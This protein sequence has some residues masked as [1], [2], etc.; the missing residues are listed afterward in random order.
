MTARTG[1]RPARCGCR[2][3]GAVPAAAAARAWCVLPACVP[4]CAAPASAPRCRVPGAAVRVEGIAAA[5][6]AQTLR[7]QFDDALHRA[8]QLAVMANHQQAFGPAQQLLDQRL[9]AGPVEVIAGFVEDK[10]IRL[11]QPGANRLDRCCRP[12][13]GPAPP[14]LAARQ[15]V[16]RR[17]GDGRKF[18]SVRRITCGH[19]PAHG[20]R[21]PAP[22]KESSC[23]SNRCVKTPTRLRGW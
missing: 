18:R 15:P 10:K 8:R 5:I 22:D 23:N 3:P 9:A 2:P 6:A 20:R 11:R 16:A 17:C 7:R 1:L 21:L 14:R 12:R 19:R 4:A 13:Y